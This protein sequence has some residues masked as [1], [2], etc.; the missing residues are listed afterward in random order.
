MNRL[1]ISCIVALVVSSPAWG[2]DSREPKAPDPS[3]GDGETRY[4]AF[5][6]FTSS[7]DPKFAM[8]GE[9]M[10]PLSGL[11][12]GAAIRNAIDDIKR[13]IGTVGDGHARLAV[14]LGPLS[15]DHTDDEL[16]RFIETAFGLALETDV[17][18]GFHLDDSIFWARRKDLWGD[19]K[20]VEAID[21][22]GTPCTAR[23]LDW[24][25]QPSAA[26]PQMCF[27]SEAILLAVKQRSTLL[28]KAIRA[29]VKRLQQREKPEL[30][31]GVI[32]GWETMI[33]QDFKTGQ[34]LGYRAL[35]NRGFNRE[36]RPK[37]MDLERE[38]VVQEFI[39]HWTEGLAGAG[40]A[41]ERIY[42][43]TA[44][45]SSKVF[46]NGE[47]PGMSYSRY[48]HFAPPSVAFGKRHRPGF[49]TY[50]QPG[51]FDDIHAQL[52]EHKQAG[53]ASS[54]GTNLQ[55]GSKPGQSGMNMETYLAKTF[56]HG[57]TLVNIFS[58]GV[59]GDAMKDMDF[60]VVTEGDEALRAYRKFLKGETL[61]EVKGESLT[62]MER[63][64]AKI[65]KIQQLL[66]AWAQKTG[67][68]E[69]A[70]AMMQ[71]LDGH[72]KAQELDK[73]EKTA[74]SILSMI[75]AGAQSPARGNLEEA[76]GKLRHEFGGPF[77]V[78]RDKVQ[79][80]LKL[81]QPQKESLDHF[82]RE[83]LPEFVPFLQKLEGLNPEQRDRER[84][85]Y[86]PKAR[87]RLMAV[88]RKSLTEPQRT[89][90]R[91]LELQREGLFGDPEA[92]KDLHVTDEQRGRFMVLI[93]GMQQKIEPLMKQAENGAN[94][95][96]IQRKVLKLR[97]DLERSLESL[98]TDAQKAQWEQMLG[99]PVEVE[100]L[101][102]LSMP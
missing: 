13:R 51:L 59:G 47:H 86:R 46:K 97:G 90:L 58:W 9:G 18:V 95:A 66:P 72:L 22:D 42:S 94:P 82:L 5:Q 35:M 31:A 80:E 14:M 40:V 71:K 15:F 89:R 100:A 11:P 81:T 17:A 3:K 53:W 84:S 85:E 45:L 77:L 7:P 30:F 8:S 19:P 73:A 37:E 78:L 60:R 75:A 16:T 29:G 63:L 93:Q 4:L 50:P 43:H 41:P 83:S 48:N 55:L 2:Q 102:D 26:P 74:D 12:D 69:R 92:L 96:D 87:A 33:G 70:T 52:A 62:L 34:Y 57:G 64:P 99:E 28:G 32:A 76:S 79:E 10:K 49:S 27:N 39:G 21:W 65:H 1:V 36:H 23:R 25:P 38:R 91:Q 24:G 88:L 61:V 68:M 6:V 54:E 20:N 67:S 98:L 101:F 56:N 44:F